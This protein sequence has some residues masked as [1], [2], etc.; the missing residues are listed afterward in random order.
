MYICIYIYMYIYIHIYTHI[1][2]HKR[3]GKTP[4]YILKIKKIFKKI[5]YR[6]RA[7]PL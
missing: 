6:Y 3:V 7:R 2:T 4:I 5:E 1:H